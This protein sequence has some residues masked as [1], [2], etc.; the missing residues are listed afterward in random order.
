MAILSL[1]IVVIVV[2]GE[3]QE[4]S[5]EGCKRV[6]NRLFQFVYKKFASCLQVLKVI[7]RLI[8]YT[9]GCYGM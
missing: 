4:K 9:Q 7:L 3:I 1:V 2:Y 6:E 5:R 8:R